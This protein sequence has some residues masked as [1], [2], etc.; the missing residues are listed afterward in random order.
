MHEIRLSAFNGGLDLKK[1]IATDQYPVDRW[2]KKGREWEWEPPEKGSV[3]VRLESDR[4]VTD[5]RVSQDLLYHLWAEYPL[6]EFYHEFQHDEYMQ[7]CLRFGKGIRPMRR[8]DLVW[9]F[10]EPLVTQNTSITHINRME[11]LLKTNYGN[12]RTLN[13]Q[14]LARASEEELKRKCRLGYR[15]K[16]V[17]QMARLLATGELVPEE[18]KAMRTQEARQELVK[19]PGI[20]PKVADLI[21]LYGLGK[22]DAFPMDVWLKRALQREYFSGKPVSEA[23]LRAFALDYFG[24]H[25]GIAHVYMFYYER[26]V[27]T[28]AEPG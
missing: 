5:K 19:L 9:A 14:A 26:K 3:L 1:T 22:P 24:Q 17:L 10:I 15:A 28:R 12:G 21:L 2:K 25:A 23:K 18:F 16:Y 7:N 13:V 4:L 8:L 11:R 20:G 6:E 27:R